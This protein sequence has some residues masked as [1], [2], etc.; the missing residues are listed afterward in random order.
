MD[1]HGHPWATI[2]ILSGR[3]S[4]RDTYSA[5]MWSRRCRQGRAMQ[6]IGMSSWMRRPDDS[7]LER[8]S[9]VQ[10]SR[11]LRPRM[12]LWVWHTP[13]HGC[14]VGLPEGWPECPCPPSLNS[15]PLSSRNFAQLPYCTSFQHVKPRHLVPIFAA[16]LMLNSFQESKGKILKSV[17]PITYDI[18]ASLSKL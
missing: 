10:R 18:R 13:A 14:R 9:I 2:R 17:R 4:C 12:E 7:D 16:E 11:T 3:K 1:A 8:W 15:N 5:L 6:L